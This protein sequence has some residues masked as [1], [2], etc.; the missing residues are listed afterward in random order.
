LRG[1]TERARAYHPVCAMSAAARMTA[2]EYFAVSVE[3]DFTELI[4]GRIE[5]LPDLAVEVRSPS[6]WRY[7]VGK[8][9]ATYERGGL[10]ELWP[11]DTATWNRA[12]VPPVVEGRGALRR[13][14]RAGLFGERAVR[15]SVRSHFGPADLAPAAGLLAPG[16]AALRALRPPRPAP[17]A[18]CLQG[19]RRAPGAPHSSFVPDGCVTPCGRRGPRNRRFRA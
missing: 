12:R 15:E 13:G 11:V 1:E 5:S 14:A 9:K 10:P 17:D 3:R 7:D 18:T 4:D 2:E 8:K 19:P 6:T 16:R